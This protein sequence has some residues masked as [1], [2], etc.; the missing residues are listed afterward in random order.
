MTLKG[1]KRALRI[2]ATAATV[3]LLVIETL[4]KSDARTTKEIRD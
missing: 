2:I 1:I 4:E 3:A